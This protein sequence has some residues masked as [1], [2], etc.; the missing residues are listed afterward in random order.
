MSD[1]VVEGDMFS[2]G[3]VVVDGRVEGKLSARSVV[4]NNSGSVYGSLLAED[5]DVHGDLQGQICIKGL[6]NIMSTGSVSG[7]VKYDK[8]AMAEGAILSATLRNVPPHMAGDLD[9]TVHRGG[10]VRITTRDL[11]AFDPDDAPEDLTYTVFTTVNGY[12]ALE[13]ADDSSIKSFTQ[14]DIVG[15]RVIFVHDGAAASRAGF[16]VI[17][18]DAKGATSGASQHVSVAVQE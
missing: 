12:V 11:T 14:A 8:I 9:L 16:D 1:T 4:I 10:R 17:V 15:G 6:I 18:A 3:R 5:A 13:P 7:D 2:N